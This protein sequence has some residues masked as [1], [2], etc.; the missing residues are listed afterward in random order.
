MKKQI[1]NIK[2]QGSKQKTWF[3]N[4]ASFTIIVDVD[5]GDRI[6]TRYIQIL[7]VVRHKKGVP[8]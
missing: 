6:I 2:V 4:Q 3:P 5:K 8:K 1:G 7:Q